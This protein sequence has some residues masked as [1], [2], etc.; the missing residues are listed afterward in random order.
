MLIPPVL[1]YVTQLSRLLRHKGVARFWSAK[2]IY[3]SSKQLGTEQ[4]YYLTE[5]TYSETCV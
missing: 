3:L 2:W 5:N 4:Y 1:L